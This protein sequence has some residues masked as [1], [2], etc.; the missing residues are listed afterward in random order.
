VVARIGVGRALIVAGLVQMAS[1]LMYVVLTFA[2]GDVRVL[3]A[4]AGIEAFTDGMADAAFLAYLSGLTNV[5]FTATQYALLSSLSGLALRTVGSLSGFAAAAL[6]WPL[7]YFA[8]VFAAVP[9]MLIMLVLL[10]RF[11]PRDA[12]MPHPAPADAP[13]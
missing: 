13:R 9:A 12:P 3:V 5:A 10:R 6:G 1:N 8:T 11:P 4:Q 7:F 2:P